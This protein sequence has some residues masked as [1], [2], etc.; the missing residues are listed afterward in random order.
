G[1]GPADAGFGVVSGRL[2]CKGPGRARGAW[3]VI[4]QAPDAPFAL[5]EMQ[6]LMLLE[7]ALAPGEGRY[8]I[9]GRLSIREKLDVAA[10]ERAGQALLDQRS[11]ARTSFALT[12]GGSGPS[13][14]VLP[15]VPF[16]LEQHDLSAL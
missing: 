9:Q 6:Q 10:L 4:P 16:I 13:Q 3:P 5:S 14:R 8:I 1:R 2:G 11:V 12:F 7:S 15:H